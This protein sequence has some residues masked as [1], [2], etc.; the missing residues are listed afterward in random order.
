M[1]EPLALVTG[2]T[3]GIGR[4]VCERLIAA[5]R[6]VIATGRDGARLALAQQQSSLGHIDRARAVLASIAPDSPYAG[7]ARSMEAWIYLD[8]GDEE[9]AARYAIEASRAGEASRG[10]AVTCLSNCGPNGAQLNHAVTQ[11]ALE[12]YLGL[13]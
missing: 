4:A 12:H 2:A 10:F 7:A 9:R 5:G 3:R 8:A 13:A 6:K 1:S 11:W